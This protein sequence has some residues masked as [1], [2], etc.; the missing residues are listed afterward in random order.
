MNE[1]GR[2]V[3]TPGGVIAPHFDPGATPRHTLAF[4]AHLSFSNVISFDCPSGKTDYGY[5]FCPERQV[6]SVPPVRLY[7]D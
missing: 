1:T 5:A 6:G 3:A 7:H 2:T 4:Y